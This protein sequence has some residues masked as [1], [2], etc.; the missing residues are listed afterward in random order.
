MKTKKKKNRQV[1]VH[2]RWLH[3]VDAKE[4]LGIENSVFEFPWKKKDLMDTL[5]RRNCIG[6]AAEFEERVVGYMVY[7]LYE[8]QLHV[9]NFAVHPDFQRHGVGRQM[10]EKLISKLHQRRNRI[11]LEV[12]ETNLAAQ[13]FFRQMGFRAKMVLHDFYDDEWGTT[14]D[15]YLMEYRHPSETCEPVNRISHLV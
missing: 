5:H 1:K 12:R 13:C 3:R 7:E 2:I 10:A 8:A 6:M 9:L 4:V 11:T 15:A 14:E